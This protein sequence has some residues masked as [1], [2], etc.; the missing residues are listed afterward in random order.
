MRFG[1]GQVDYPIYRKYDWT[2]SLEGH[3]GT[4]VAF[5][6]QMLASAFRHKS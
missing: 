2:L 1:L 6:R 3:Y 5:I 4:N